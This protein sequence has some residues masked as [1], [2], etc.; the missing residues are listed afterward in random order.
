MA[1]YPS[2]TDVYSR[3]IGNIEYHYG[4]ESEQYLRYLEAFN[5]HIEYLNKTKINNLLHFFG[6]KSVRGYYYRTFSKRNEIDI[7]NQPFEYWV[8]NGVSLIF[9][10]Q[11]LYKNIGEYQK[12][13]FSELGDSNRTIIKLSLDSSFE[14]SPNR[15][16]LKDYSEDL[17][18]YGPSESYSYDREIL[19]LYPFMSSKI[20]FN[21]GT[22]ISLPTFSHYEI[23]QS[24]NEIN[25]YWENG[26]HIIEYEY[27][28]RHTFSSFDSTLNV[29]N[30]L[31]FFKPNLNFVF[32]DYLEQIHK[33]KYVNNNPSFP[34]ISK[35]CLFD[36]F[37][38][39]KKI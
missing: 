21:F 23:E 25:D 18:I 16:F 24:S 11:L 33:W 1:F 8:S 22:F 26:K 14:F 31:L 19:V 35:C 34:K 15:S 5:K 20:S 27:F 2:Y 17:E 32:E 29:E 39:T 37:N 10:F 36:I 9:P 28:D 12:F 4:R 38:K 7:N 6:V 13:D 3:A 30:Q